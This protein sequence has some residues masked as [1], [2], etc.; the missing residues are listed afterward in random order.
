M[1]ASEIKHMECCPRASH[2]ASKELD[3][4]HME[5]CFD[6]ISFPRY[7]N[8]EVPISAIVTDPNNKVISQATNLPIQACDPTAHA[9][10]NAIRL[11]SQHL[12]NYRLTGC[13]IYISLE[14]CPMCFYAIMQAR[15]ARIIFSA[16]DSKIGIL[17][18]GVYKHTHHLGNHHF[19]WTSGIL[20]KRGKEIL[21][22]FFESKRSA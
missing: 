22:T 8:K 11:A 18:N 10:I 16:P 17:S 1:T 3:Q 2:T 7:N 19:T 12:S 14:P 21:Q 5:R 4:E 6:L 13:T 15:I 9:E 20:E